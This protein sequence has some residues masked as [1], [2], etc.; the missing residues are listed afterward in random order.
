MSKHTALITIIHL[1]SVDQCIDHW[2][3]LH[4]LAAAQF[5]TLGANQRYYRICSLEHKS[6]ESW[7]TYK[8]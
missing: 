3:S 6:L 8:V 5:S 2:L 4:W 7:F 1:S